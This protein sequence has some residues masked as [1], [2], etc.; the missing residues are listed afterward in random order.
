MDVHRILLPNEYSQTMSTPGAVATTTAG[1]ETA[2]GIPILRGVE[3]RCGDCGA[4]NI[5]KA[6]GGGSR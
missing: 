3:Y 4:R 1:G 2:G 6:S 5:I